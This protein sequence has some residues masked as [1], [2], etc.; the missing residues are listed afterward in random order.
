M[1]GLSA[2]SSS[3]PAPPPDDPSPASSGPTVPAESVQP[4]DEAWDRRQDEATLTEIIQRLEAA[5]R[6]AP[7]APVLRVRLAEAYHRR[8]MAFPGDR[9]PRAD[10]EAG[11]D[12]AEQALRQVPELV[13]QLKAGRTFDE[14]LADEELPI[15]IDPLYWYAENLL[16]FARQ[17]GMATLLFYRDRLQTAYG[18]LSRA[19]P[20][21][22]G[23][24]PWRGLGQ[25]LSVLPEFGGRDL[26]ASKE[27]FG[28]AGGIEA[29][30]WN[31]V[32]EAETWAVEADEPA[33]GRRLLQAVLDA[34]VDSA[35]GGLA[36]A[37]AR[38]LLDQGGYPPANAPAEPG[39]NGSKEPKREEAP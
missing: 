3:G 34:D 14:I 26:K 27:A 22:Q 8:G 7:E 35:D 29:S 20:D 32:A 36:Q 13:P 19:A 37:R 5:V 30:L 2:C 12:Q 23:G 6:D 33:E 16:S 21:H 24:G 28:Q 4:V 39:P 11:V 25:L 10:F 15:A 38:W 17:G 1:A 9:D 31:G 18:R